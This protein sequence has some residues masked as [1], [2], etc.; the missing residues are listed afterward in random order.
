MILDTEKKNGERVKVKRHQLY[1]MG[2]CNRANILLEIATTNNN[3]FVY[4]CI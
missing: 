1:M 3:I 2:D 4:I